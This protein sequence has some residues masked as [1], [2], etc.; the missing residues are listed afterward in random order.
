MSKATLLNVI[1][2]I[3]IAI[4]AQASI[5]AKITD[6]SGDVKI[7]R[8]VEEHWQT[9][10][11]GILLEEIDTILTEN[12][13]WAVLETSEGKT[14]KLGSNAVLDIRDLRDT[15]EKDLFL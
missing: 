3:L 2:I 10:K 9:T 4:S 7:R 1:W 11:T 13:A 14:F 6:L 12:D 15:T 5:T 8:G